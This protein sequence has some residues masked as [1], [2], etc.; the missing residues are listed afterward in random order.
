[1]DYVTELSQGQLQDEICR[2]SGLIHVKLAWKTSTKR[3]GRRLKVSKRYVNLILDQHLY[4]VLTRAAKR[5]RR[6][7]RA[8]AKE[9]VKKYLKDLRPPGRQHHAPTGA[10]ADE[11]KE[12]YSQLQELIAKSENLLYTIER[13]RDVSEKRWWL[14]E[15]AQLAEVLESAKKEMKK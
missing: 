1:M 7:R 9:A 2:L 13:D 6:S 4:E 8:E 14:D 5:N 12:I 10:R 15:R 3:G 11:H